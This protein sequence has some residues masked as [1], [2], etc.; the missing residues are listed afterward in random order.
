MK[1]SYQ[2]TV[3]IL[4]E[5]ACSPHTRWLFL[6]S[7]VTLAIASV[8]TLPLHAG[9]LAYH[10]VLEVVQTVSAFSLA[11]LCV[12]LARASVKNRIDVGL[13]GASNGVYA[14]AVSFLTSPATHG[15]ALQIWI[16]GLLAAAGAMLGAFLATQLRR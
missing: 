9:G 13:I 3:N 12:G 15:T 1:R 8:H 6:A 11:G 4:I 5:G 16:G 10:P 2:R 7:L 14:I